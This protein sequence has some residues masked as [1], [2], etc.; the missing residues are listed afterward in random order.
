MSNNIKILSIEVETTRDEDDKRDW[1]RAYIIE[2]HTCLGFTKTKRVPVCRLCYP[3]DKFYVQGRRN[4][5]FTRTASA[6]KSEEDALKAAHTY[7]DQNG[8]PSKLPK[9]SVLDKKTFT[10]TEIR[11]MSE[12]NKPLSSEELSK[13]FA[14]LCNLPHVPHFWEGIKERIEGGYPHTLD[15]CPFSFSAWG[16]EKGI[17]MWGGNMKF[18]IEFNNG[19]YLA[20]QRNASLEFDLLG[21]VPTLSWAEAICY[22]ANNVV[23]QYN[24]G[25]TYSINGKV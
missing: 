8:E 6:Y 22:V 3:Y 13:Q 2:E 20:Y 18:K 7:I 15:F 11:T 23:M 21:T 10:I 4:V 9:E 24:A 12:T 25:T 14:V 5:T 17:V 16:N 1:Y 19:T